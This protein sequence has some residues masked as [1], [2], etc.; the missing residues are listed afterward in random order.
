M[1][2]DGRERTPARHVCGASRRERLRLRLS[3]GT[4]LWIS[5]YATFGVECRN[6]TTIRTLTT[7]T[8]R[9]ASSKHKLLAT[10]QW[11]HSTTEMPR[12]LR[13][14]GAARNVWHL[15]QRAKIKHRMATVQLGWSYQVCWRKQ[16][17]HDGR[18]QLVCCNRQLLR[19]WWSGIWRKKRGARKW[20]NQN[21]R[22]ISRELSFGKA[23]M[24]THC[25]HMQG[26]FAHLYW[27]HQC[28]K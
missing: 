27:Q 18:A 19:Q 10:A 8:T 4:L 24:N 28:C 11:P 14:H 2:E 3:A 25:E 22:Q 23:Q 17:Q 26:F 20:W 12:V 5:Q 21:S 1:R 7:M 9:S 13:A 15:D 16:A 6:T